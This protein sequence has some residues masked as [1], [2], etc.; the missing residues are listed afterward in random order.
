MKKILAILTIIGG[1]TAA[2]YA[3]G[4]FQ[5]GAPSTALVAKKRRKQ[6]IRNN[7]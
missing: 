2:S 3:Q 6:N 4:T 7:G 1:I 5:W